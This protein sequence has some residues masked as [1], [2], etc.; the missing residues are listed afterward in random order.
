MKNIFGV[1]DISVIVILVEV[2]VLTIAFEDIFV[3]G[4]LAVV[5]SVMCILAVD[6][7]V[8]DFAVAAVFPNPT[9]IQKSIYMDVFQQFANCI[10]IHN[11]IL[12]MQ[13]A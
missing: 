1:E 9:E 3:V 8:E 10:L 6:I 5:E 12:S 13:K 7:F 11:S 2:F 4:N